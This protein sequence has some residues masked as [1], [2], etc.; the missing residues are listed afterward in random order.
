MYYIA[1]VLALRLGDI[2]AQTHDCRPSDCYD[3]SCYGLSEGKDGPHTIYPVSPNLKPVN[4]SCDQETTGGGWIMYQRRVNGKLNFTRTWEE[5]KHGFGDNGGNTTELWLGNEKF[6]QLVHGAKTVTVRVEVDAFDG[7]QCWMEADNFTLSNEALLYTTLWNSSTRACMRKIRGPWRRHRDR[8]FRT[9]DKAGGLQTCLDEYKGGWWYQDDV[10]CAPLFING[11][12]LSSA[13]PDRHSI[14]LDRFK[15]VSLER[16]RMMFRETN[17]VHACDNPCKHNGTCVHVSNPRSH[18]CVCK[19]D[20]CGAECEL[21]NPC[22]NGGTCEYRKTTNSTT[23]KCSAAFCG[24][25]CELKNPCKNGGTCEYRK[26]TNS[27]TCKCSA[28]FCGPECE[29]KN[30]CKNGG[31]CEYRK[32]TKSTTCKCSARFVGPK[33]EDAVTT[34][35]TTPPT[36]L[37]TSPS[38]MTST[39][40]PIIIMAVGGGILLLLILCGIG[41]TAG[42]II[43]RRQRKRKEEEEKEAKEIKKLAESESFQGYMLSMFGFWCCMW[44]RNKSSMHNVLSSMWPEHDSLNHHRIYS[45]NN[46]NCEL[47]S[48]L[49]QINVDE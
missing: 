25:E 11:E 19:T 37:S 38:T 30:P 28:A 7:T 32:T 22:K 18:R 2:S 5:Y 34:P 29:L 6:Y 1:V 48:Y 16:S 8:P 45:A 9:F 39:N 49:T 23:C 12:Y 47:Q 10:D 44:R 17:H 26:T 41:I 14:Y 21:Q 3:L 46:G 15:T 33:C 43:K 40:A 35:S 42:V 4:V 13:K 24:L 36:T 31:T 27:T 20:F